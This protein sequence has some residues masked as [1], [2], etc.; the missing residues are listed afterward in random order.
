MNILLMN[1]IFQYINRNLDDTFTSIKIQD[2]FNRNV[3]Q[4]YYFAVFIN[5][6]NTFNMIPQKL[7]R[8]MFN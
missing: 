3:V 6:N 1:C 5:I 7:Y 2:V 8:K 4:S